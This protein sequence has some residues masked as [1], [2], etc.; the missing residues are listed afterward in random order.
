MPQQHQVTANDDPAKTCFDSLPTNPRWSSLNAR[1]PL[2]DPRQATV[3]MLADNA[4]PSGDELGALSQWAN[5]RKLCADMAI[6]FRQRYAPPGVAGIYERQQ[7]AILQSIASL[8]AGEVTYGQFNV[9]RQH[10]TTQAIAEYEA[11]RSQHAQQ[12][13]ANQAQRQ[14]ESQVQFQQ[15]IQLLQMA[16]PQP[17]PMPNLMQPPVECIT[18]PTLGGYRTTC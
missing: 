18:R 12:A 1:I 11:L 2:A 3:Q 16:R 4:K 5:A 6:T 17:M 7:M 14:A 13:Q 9:Q 10:I 8:Y 15:G